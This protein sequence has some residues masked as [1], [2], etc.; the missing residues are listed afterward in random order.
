MTNGGL[1]VL[2]LAAIA[3]AC[4]GVDLQGTGD[5]ATGDS[6]G[7]DGTTEVLLA[8][9]DAEP[10]AVPDGTTPFGEI[11]GT[12]FSECDPGEGCFLDKCVENSDCL[13]GWCE[14]HMGE[15]V[16]TKLCQDECPPGWTCSKVMGTGPDVLYVC[17]S[18]YANLCKPCTT[19]ADCKSPGGV[20]DVCLDYAEEGNFC[21][22]ICTLEGGDGEGPRQSCP[23][24]FTCKE[25]VTVDGFNKA[26]CVADAGTCPCTSKSI[27]LS[28]WTPCEVDNDWGLCEGK[29][30]C[31][32]EGLS[33]CDAAVPAP[34]ECNALDDDCDGLT[35]E[36]TCDDSNSCTQDTCAGALGCQQVPLESG[37]CVDGDP[38]TVADH[39]QDG[40]C[41]G[42]PVECKDDNLC[43]DDLCTATGG[44]EFVFN[45]LPC[46]DD[47]PCTLGD[48]CEQGECTGLAVPCDCLVDEDCAA[49]E[50]GDLCNGSLVC[51]TSSLPHKCI[52]DPESVVECEAPMG[53]DAP[54]LAAMC[55]PSTGE[56]SLVA[57]GNSGP[58]DD[59]NACSTGEACAEGS[60][61][62]GTPLNCNDGNPCTDDS[63][64]AATGCTHSFNN[65]SCFDGSVCTVGDSCEA[66]TCVAGETSVD[67]T[68]G[69]PC[70]QDSCDPDSGCLHI[71][72]DGIECDDGNACTSGEAC[73]QGLCTPAELVTCDDGDPC[74]TGVCDPAQGCTYTLNTA[75]CD[76]GDACTT[77]D[78]CHLGQCI[79]AGAA[80]CLDGNPCTDD[81]CDPETGCVFKPNAANCDDGSACTLGDV[82]QA[83][84]CKSQEILGCGDDNPCTDDGCDPDSGCLHTPTEGPCNDGNPCTLGDQCEDGECLP[85]PGNDCDDGNPCTDD[86]CGQDGECLH[87]FNTDPCD[88]DSVCTQQA[89]CQ[90]GECVGF[91]PID[92]DDGNPC[93]QDSCHAQNNCQHLP[94][95][96]G[97]EDGNPCTT[98]DQCVAG[99][100]TPG[101]PTNCDDGNPCTQ[102]SCEPLTGCV[103]AGA[104]EET[105]DGEDNDCDGLIDEED[106]CPEGTQATGVLPCDTVWTAAASPYHVTG[107]IVV[108]AN[109]KLTI[110]PGTVVKFYVSDKGSDWDHR[111]YLQVDGELEA[112]GTAE[113]PIVLT[114]DKPSPAKGNWGGLYIMNA[115]THTLRHVHIMYA[116]GDSTANED[117]A[118]ALHSGQYL[119]DSC[120]FYK[121]DDAIRLH[122]GGAAG[123]LEVTGSHFEQVDRGIL[124][125][126]AAGN[127]TLTGNTFVSANTPLYVPYSV[128]AIMPVTHNLFS[129]GGTVRCDG[130]NPGLT[131]HKNTFDGTGVWLLSGC[132]PNMTQNNFGGNAEY[133]LELWNFN[134]NPA[135]PVSIDASGNWWGEDVTAEMTQGGPDANISKILDYHDDFTLGKVLYEGWLQ[136][137]VPDAGP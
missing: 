61:T 7:R 75:P 38:C 4:T 35:D 80:L 78:H 15:G 40:V 56:C 122:A 131:I 98:G 14:E 105:C 31:L 3:T 92:C 60:C 113:S 121:T 125:M 43:T 49:M 12:P 101:G 54:C 34:E 55:D 5:S 115:A 134:G 39:C 110:E 2:A 30:V 36:D 120:R 119:I 77:G 1:A 64:E 82:C 137:P 128:G 9:T 76:D 114:A 108:L 46:D 84:Q 85:G 62:A 73:A 132:A 107:S 18:G 94:I 136:E 88:D 126:G 95:A 111:L 57:T 123:S 74:T 86:G 93:T 20:D 65:A 42:T 11:D 129:G 63:C 91:D 72:L 50:D 16:C 117:T 17:V 112:L 104:D 89:S 27:A 58:C 71:A 66:G 103:H 24:G 37:E 118:L 109:C 70:T 52:T 21:G 133:F 83:G 59:N 99:E 44:C 106:A 29:R 22:G 67:C 130:S 45:D 124:V 127:V 100:C 8:A 47:D 25:A 48:A 19:S 68:D 79:F 135:T 10:E 26:Q 23:W 13:S 53:P 69:N 33:L 97:C 90:A 116:G 96:G 28:L 41:A 81:G 102:D 51:N 32:E 87:A 6:T